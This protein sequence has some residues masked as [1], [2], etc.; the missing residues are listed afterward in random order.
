MDESRADGVQGFERGPEGTEKLADTPVIRVGPGQVKCSLQ[1]PA[2]PAVPISP[3]ASAVFSALALAA[4]SAAWA[5]VE[6]ALGPIRRQLGDSQRELAGGPHAALS[7]TPASLPVS[8][9]GSAK[10]QPADTVAREYPKQQPWRRPSSKKPPT[11]PLSGI[12]EIRTFF[13]TNE[14]P[15][16]FFGPTAFNLLGIDRWV[17][18]FQYIAYYDSW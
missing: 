15:I 17:L 16:Y 5:G 11:R 10:S 12:S 3:L 2:G 4:A 7:S 14:Q 6:R 13:R 1:R 9:P 8:A 18:N